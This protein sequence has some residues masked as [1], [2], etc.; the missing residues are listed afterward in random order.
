MDI[1]SDEVKRVRFKK[2][3]GKYIAKVIEKNNYQ[4]TNNDWLQLLTDS[5]ISL[6]IY[7]LK[8]LNVL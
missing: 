1:V 2:L 7:S 6:I 4:L 3:Q 5:D 8:G